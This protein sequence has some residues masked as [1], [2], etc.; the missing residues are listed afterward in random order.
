MV[1]ILM[2]IN[3]Y[4][5]GGYFV[6][7]HWWLLMVVILMA[8]VLMVIGG[9]WWLFLVIILVT[10]VLMV[11]NIAKVPLEMPICKCAHMWIVPNIITS[12]VFKPTFT[13]FPSLNLEQWLPFL[14]I[15][16]IL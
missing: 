2:I 9:Y 14:K 6:S 16:T 10:I 15:I 4:F 11:I 3:G 1:I 8:I 12:I 13:W 5:I 7:G